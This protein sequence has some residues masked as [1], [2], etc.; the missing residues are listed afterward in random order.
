MGKPPGDVA[1]TPFGPSKSLLVYILLIHTLWLTSS[2]GF[3]TYA[4]L[5]LVVQVLTEGFVDNRPAV[6]IFI[7][8][9]LGVFA[10][11]S[12]LM[13]LLSL[14]RSLADFRHMNSVR[15]GGDL[16]DAGYYFAPFRKTAAWAFA[17][18]PI[19]FVFVVLSFLADPFPFE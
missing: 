10:A 14:R 18:L 11:W 15:D 19:F 5:Y 2:V 12:A 9:Y 13:W 6:I 3:W 1:G 7:M 8:I 4:A 17:S 16:D